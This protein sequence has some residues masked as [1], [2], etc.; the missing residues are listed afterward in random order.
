[1]KPSFRVLSASSLSRHASRGHTTGFIGLGRM[2]YEMAYNL[3]SRTLVE[4]GGSARFVVCDAQEE[5]AN[6]FAKN[7]HNQFPGAR[8]DVVTTPAE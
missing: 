1:M 3:F 6:A 4:T 7:F 8:I 5:T 2:G